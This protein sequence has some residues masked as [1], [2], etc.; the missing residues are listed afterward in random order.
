M[1][2]AAS[3]NLPAVSAR[4][5]LVGLSPSGRIA[6]LP[7][8]RA[9]PGREAPVRPPVLSP[10]VAPPAAAPEAEHLCQS[11]EWCLAL[12]RWRVV[13]NGGG[14][15][16]GRWGGRL[17]K[18]WRGRVVV[19]RGHDLELAS[20][21]RPGPEGEGQEAGGGEDREAQDKRV[22]VAASP[23]VGMGEGRLHGRGV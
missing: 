17:S 8:R 9:V 22:H 4:L 16:L 14:D 7:A 5:Q 1:Q 2:E 11:H 10:P 20:R 19:G 23:P 21:R 3:Y 13:D 12:G 15:R 18:D 6:C